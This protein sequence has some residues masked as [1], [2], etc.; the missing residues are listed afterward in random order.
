MPIIGIDLGTTNSCAYTCERNGTPDL[1][2]IQG[3]STLPSMVALCDGIV[4]VGE[5]ALAIQEDDPHLVAREFK[6][7]MGR[8]FSHPSVQEVLKRFN[9]TIKPSE[10]GDSCSILLEN[11]TFTPQELSSF[12]L[13]RLKELAED[14]RAVQY[15]EAVITVPAYFNDAQKDATKQ[16]GEIAGLKVLRVLEEPIAAA[17]AYRQANPDL[18]LEGKIILVFDLGGGTFDITLVKV[19]KQS[20]EVIDTDGD[21]MLGGSDFDELLFEY[22]LNAADQKYPDHN[23]RKN[24]L[25]KS[26]LRSR[27]EQA[28]KRLSTE[29][30]ARISLK[31]ARSVTFS[32]MI[33]RTVFEGLCQPKFDQ[34]MN[35]VAGLLKRRGMTSDDI[36]QVLLVGGSTRIAKIR[37]MLRDTFGKDKVKGDLRVDE[38][39]GRGASLAVNNAGNEGNVV[40]Q[41]I[42]AHSLG[43]DFIRQST[44][45]YHSYLILDKSGSMYSKRATPTMDWVQQENILGAVVENTMKFAETRA[46]ESPQDRISIITFNSSANVVVNG[47]PVTA[48]GEL[49]DKLNAIIPAGTTDYLSGLST[50]FQLAS[51]QTELQPLFVMLSDGCDGRRRTEAVQCVE[52]YFASNIGCQMHTIGFGNP[53]DFKHLKNLSSIAGGSHYHSSD[54]ISLGKAFD[55]IAKGTATPMGNQTEECYHI[56]PRRTRIPASSS[57]TFVNCFDNQKEISVKV[58]EGEKRLVSENLLLA[59]FVFEI[60]PKPAGQSKIVVVF[61]VDS[62]GILQVTASADGRSRVVRINK[63]PGVLS[64][65]QMFNAQNDCD[66]L[67]LRSKLMSLFGELNEKIDTLPLSKVESIV[68]NRLVQ[69]IDNVLKRKAS[70]DEM[71]FLL[72]DCRSELASLV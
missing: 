46:K 33:Y 52:Q 64:D 49:R 3:Q 9:Y 2:D 27:S 60:D 5:P 54:S 28:K 44:T 16:A 24:S 56:I 58:L 18:D 57:A 19:N 70:V 62:N 71:Q 34:C 36:A 72:N 59:E 14:L 20:L 21:A 37:Q 22:C 38:I 8:S 41:T 23:L 35:L 61:E 17:L 39:V 12:V 48:L 68:Y 25:F 50:A 7:L 30:N 26:R 32:K 6:R 42:T 65:N 45:T 31:V 51:Q 69:Q 66:D 11:R 43:T 29:E 47:L 1:V 67:M 4:A 55:G 10:K 13:R 63:K 40:L 53:S 15:N